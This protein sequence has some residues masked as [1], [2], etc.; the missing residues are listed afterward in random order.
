MISKGSQSRHTVP[1]LR[2]SL[3]FTL[4]FHALTDVAIACQ[5]CEPENLSEHFF[6]KTISQWQ[7][8]RDS[9]NTQVEIA[10]IICIQKNEP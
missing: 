6:S 2:G 7:F 4:P 3:V 1:P 5:L 9:L 8:K 10:V